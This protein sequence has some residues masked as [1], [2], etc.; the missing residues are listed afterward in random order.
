MT[1]ATE[2]KEQETSGVTGP[3]RNPDIESKMEYSEKL[4]RVVE[5]RR[6]FVRTDANGNPQ[7]QWRNKEEQRLSDLRSKRLG[8]IDSMVAKGEVKLDGLHPVLTPAN[9][10]RARFIR[11]A[12]DIYREATHRP[13]AN[14]NRRFAEAVS[15]ALDNGQAEAYILSAVRLAAYLEP[16]DRDPYDVRRAIDCIQYPNQLLTA[17][18]AAALGEETHPFDKDESYSKPK[19]RRN[20]P[21]E[22]EIREILSA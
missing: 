7:Y 22:E 8:H 13:D 9:G 5:Y 3:P 16:A 14:V 12:W 17:R 19:R 20:M 6:Y 1:T 18:Q 21:T 2:T 4:G 11:Q 15:E 10:K